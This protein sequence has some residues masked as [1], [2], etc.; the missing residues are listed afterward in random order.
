MMTYSTF[1]PNSA[2]R[3]F[4]E[5][6][7]IVEGLDQSKQKIIPDGFSEM[8]FHF[9]DAYEISTARKTERQSL[10]LVAGQLDSPIFLKPTGRSG[11]FGIK[12]KPT[13]MW[14]LFGFQMSEL[15]N[16]TISFTD[17]FR[18]QIDSITERLHMASHN[19]ERVNIIESFL[20]FRSNSCP[21]NSIADQII[22]SIH[23]SKGR[24]RI[25]DHAK[26][27][28]LSTRKLER[29]FNQQVGISAKVYSRLIRFNNVIGMLQN[30]SLSKSD[31][32][33][34]AGY[35]DQSHFNREF[36]E[37]SGENPES[38]IRQNHDFANFFLSR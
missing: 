32:S 5:C 14:K 36:K 2:L 3:P 25:G 13:G 34:L 19:I 24:V 38:W 21:E 20:C 16:E 17:M 28:K 27:L 8:I 10:T 22:E 23:G 35:F 31:L 6:Y 9:S 12:F 15:M 7:W 33:Y 37:F 1:V 30:S 26:N 4:V 11:V 29:I 18:E